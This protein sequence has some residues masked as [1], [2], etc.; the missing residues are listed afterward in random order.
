[1]HFEE[2]DTPP[3]QNAARKAPLRNKKPFAPSGYQPG[4]VE[5]KTTTDHNGKTST[6]TTTH[7]APKDPLTKRVADRTGEAKTALENAGGIID[8]AGNLRDKA[9]KIIKNADGAPGPAANVAP[10]ASGGAPATTPTAEQ[11]VGWGSKDHPGGGQEI[12]TSVKDTAAKHELP[13]VNDGQREKDN[14]AAPDAKTGKDI[15]ADDGFIEYI[16]GWEDFANKHKDVLASYGYGRDRE[17]GHI[18]K[19]WASVEDGASSVWHGLF[20]GNIGTDSLAPALYS[21]YHMEDSVRFG[22]INALADQAGQAHS[23]AQSGVRQQASDMGSMGEAWVG[24]GGDAAKAHYG[25]NKGRSADD[26]INALDTA[27]VGIAATGH[28]IAELLN[29]KKQTVEDIARELKDVIGGNTEQRYEQLIELVKPGLFIAPGS[30]AGTLVNDLREVGVEVVDGVRSITEKVAGFLGK[31][32]DAMQSGAHALTFG[33]VPAPKAE[34]HPGADRANKLK[35]RLD[36]LHLPNIHQAEI[37]LQTFVK[38]LQTAEQKVAGLCDKVHAK[39]HELLKNLPPDPGETATPPGGETP[40]RVGGNTA[41]GT[42]AGAGSSTV[43]GGTPAEQSSTGSDASDGAGS[44]SGSGSGGGGIGSAL[45]SVGQ[46]LGSV[47]QALGQSVSGFG[48]AL[49]GVLQG[50]MGSIGQ[51]IQTAAQAGRQAQQDKN[52]DEDDKGKDA[53]DKKD[54]GKDADGEAKDGEDQTKSDQHGGASLST[55]PNGPG[56]PVTP[57]VST[58]PAP[59]HAP[60]AA[61]GG[62]GRKQG[63]NNHGDFEVQ[64]TVHPVGAGNQGHITGFE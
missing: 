52:N 24:E 31:L 35:T 27:H 64:A 4:P 49:G 3:L 13:D 23:A 29:M 17:D 36:E 46:A 20:G 11:Q 5:H 15:L 6:E 37:D 42:G 33:A 63:E 14:R 54:T 19:V 57:A 47:G 53:E 41:G 39:G 16:M 7:Y 59:G 50:L 1:M 2:T 30:V 40:G 8:A 32:Y 9:G 43:G 48:S 45:G 56:Q 12:A 51:I 28:N 62:G 61:R 26:T 10:S 22:A 34:D 38:G 44:G 21:M 18:G 25:T 60:A 58:A 55:V